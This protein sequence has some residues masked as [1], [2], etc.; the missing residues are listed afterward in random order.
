M[1]A[2]LFVLALGLAGFAR[3]RRGSERQELALVEKAVNRAVVSC[4]A[5]EGFYPPN[6]DYLIEH[7]GLAVDQ[8]RYY[9]YHEAFAPNVYPTIWVARR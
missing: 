8:E 3:V 1:A 4:Y 2:F 7:Y 6:I 5:L 9:I